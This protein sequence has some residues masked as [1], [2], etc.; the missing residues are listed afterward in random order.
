MFEPGDKK[1]GGGSREGTPDAPDE[2]RMIQPL[3]VIYGNRARPSP[4][5]PPEPAPE[6]LEQPQPQPLSS[7]PP[8]T[9]LHLWAM[10]NQ[11]QSWSSLV[12]VPSHEG[13]SAMDAARAILEVASRQ[14]Q[15]TLHFLDAEGL[16]LGVARHVVGEMR[17]YVEQGDRVIVLLDSIISNPV[18]LEVALAADRALLC[19]TLGSSDYTSARRTLE[20]IG[21]ERFV[22]SVT[23]Q[24][25]SGAPKK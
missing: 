16:E 4:E 5:T 10:L 21:K 18:G 19:V 22:G 25:P 17:A 8:S 14:E 24:P 12:L 13:G 15:G 11:R 1:Q 7:A 6:V 2:Q 20:L 9:L 3:S 23:L